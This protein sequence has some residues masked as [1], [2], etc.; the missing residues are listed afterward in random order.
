MA[1]DRVRVRNCICRWLN[2]A[3]MTNQQL[4]DATGYSKK[5]IMAVVS[6]MQD[7]NAIHVHSIVKTGEHGNSRAYL[8]A[9]GP[10]PHGHRPKISGRAGKMPP[11]PDP[12]LFTL[13]GQLGIPKKTSK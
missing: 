4:A 2:Q 5:V 11:Y 1:N 9:L 10:A 13:A 12:Y 8:L 6:Q 7:S 3:P